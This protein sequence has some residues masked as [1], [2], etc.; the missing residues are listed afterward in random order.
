MQESIQAAMS[1]VRGRSKALGMETDFYQKNDL[2]IHVPEGATPKDGPSAGVGMCVAIVSV[3][4]GIPVRAEVA[5][6]GEITLRGE[7]LPI[8]GLKEKLLAALRGGIR[9]V[10]IPEENKRHLQEI[11]DN[12]KRHLDIRPVRWIE[13]VLDV[14]LQRMPTPQKAEPSELKEK[15]TQQEE[16][17]QETTGQKNQ[18]LQTH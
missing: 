5:M 11:P 14:A 3:L 1:V 7:I 18:G 10:L 4:T 8:G 12:I 2:H 16:V 13:E 17:E 9:I 15:T 6:T